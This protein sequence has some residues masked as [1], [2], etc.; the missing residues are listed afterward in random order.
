MK[1]KSINVGVVAAVFILSLV[2]YIVFIKFIKADS[3]L[4]EAEAFREQRIP[5][6]PLQDLATSTD[7][8]SEVIKGKVLLVYSISSC[9]ACKKELQSLS[10]S[11][12]DMDSETKIFGVMFEGENVVK[13]Y[14][15]QNNI[16][17]PI[18]IDK[19][20]RLFRELDLKY[21]PS[22]LMLNNGQIKKAFFGFPKDKQGL[23]A[24]TQY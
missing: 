2:S 7:Y 14:V 1:F 10:Q 12:Q 19:D 21:F 20:G 13:D 9:A 4:K 16:K 11:M 3:L 17:V 8:S 18:L 22:N 15:E 5:K 24:L 23:I 6:V